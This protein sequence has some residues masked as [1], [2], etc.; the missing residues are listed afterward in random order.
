MS[1]LD[2][3]DVLVPLTLTQSHYNTRLKYFSNEYTKV[4]CF[5][6]PIFN[7]YGFEK[8]GINSRLSYSQDTSN[9]CRSDS[10]KRARD[11]CFEIAYANDFKYF[12]TLTLDQS[13]ISRTDLKPIYNAL[14]NWLSN[15]VQRRDMQY[16][17]CPE[18]HADGNAVHFHGLCNGNLPLVDSGTVI[19][20]GYE[21]PISI[22]KAARLGLDGKTV[23]NLD[24]WLYGFSTV[25]QLDENKDAVAKYILKYI[26]K[27][28]SKI[29]GKFYF[30]GGKDLKREVPTE[31][32]NYP[33]CNF[34]GD[35]HEILKGV[36]AVKYK[37]L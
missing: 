36:L 22:K 1:K 17:V 28:Q 23:Y 33:Y 29:F 26:T 8:R 37:T 10:V 31:Y 19:V 35:E 16:I 20:Q 21:K 30:S 13:K 9:E 34:D 4:S 27:E 2:N 5:S 12:V 24:N 3:S 7:P 6:K 15:G 32:Q 11:R 25:I 14:K 18:Y